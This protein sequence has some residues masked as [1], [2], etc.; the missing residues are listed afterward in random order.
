M[1]A[2]FPGSRK[3]TEDKI[4]F[5]PLLC[6]HSMVTGMESLHRET[7][8]CNRSGGGT[9]YKEK[10]TRMLVLVEKSVSTVYT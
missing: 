6:Y 2:T 4:E 1:P 8:K 5:L 9:C 3:K 10:G 7:K